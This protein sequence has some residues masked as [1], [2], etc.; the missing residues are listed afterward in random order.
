[1]EHYARPSGT[2]VAGGAQTPKAVQFYIAID[3]PKDY[4]FARL[5]ASK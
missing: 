1:M 2:W 3:K 4:I 5:A